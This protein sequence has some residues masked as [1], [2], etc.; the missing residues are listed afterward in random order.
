MSGE[1]EKQVFPPSHGGVWLEDDASLAAAVAPFGTS[2]RMFGALLWPV[3][4]R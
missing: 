4:G 3:N 1:M 2:V